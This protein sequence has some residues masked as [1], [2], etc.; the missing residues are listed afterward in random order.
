MPHHFLDGLKTESVMQAIE[1]L[2]SDARGV[3]IPR[4]FV[5]GFDL[6]KWGLD[7][8]GWEV[9]SLYD[10]ENYSYW[11]A[12]DQILSNAEYHKDGHVWRLHQDGDLWA[13]CYELMTDEEKTNFGWD[14]DF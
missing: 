12:W 8:D 1:L 4:D 6:K 2:L 11:D 7:P 13:V 14:A 3:Y 10:P 9:E 5:E